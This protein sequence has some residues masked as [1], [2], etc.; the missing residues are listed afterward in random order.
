MA[1]LP[2]HTHFIF[3]CGH[4]HRVSGFCLFL[5]NGRYPGKTPGDMPG[6]LQ[7]LNGWGNNLTPFDVSSLRSGVGCLFW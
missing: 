1:A 4:T 6:L 5:G 3:D 2:T 7:E